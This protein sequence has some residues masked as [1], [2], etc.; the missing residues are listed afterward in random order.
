MHKLSTQVIYLV[1][2]SPLI[3][4]IFLHWLLEKMGSSRV[5]GAWESWAR[6]L[7]KK[8]TGA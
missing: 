5:L 8:V 7:A 4:I 3:P 6:K 2:V 1:L